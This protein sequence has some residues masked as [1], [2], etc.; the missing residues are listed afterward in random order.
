L[1]TLRSTRHVEPRRRRLRA[2]LARCAYG[3]FR[4]DSTS[5]EPYAYFE[6]RRTLD[7]WLSETAS[8]RGSTVSKNSKILVGATASRAAGAPVGM[9]S[10]AIIRSLA[11]TVVATAFG[12][13]I[14]GAAAGVS[15]AIDLLTT[16]LGRKDREIYEKTIGRLEGD[17]DAFARSER[18]PRALIDQAL[19]AARALIAARG[20]TVSEM[21]D[22]NLDSE[23]VSD[24]VAARGRRELEPLDNDAVELC[25]QI[26]RSAYAALLSEGAAL[27]GLEVAFRRVVLTTLQELPRDVADAVRVALESFIADQHAPALNRASSPRRQLGHRPHAATASLDLVWDPS[28]GVDFPSGG[29]NEYRM[30]IALYASNERGDVMAEGVEV[31]LLRTYPLAMVRDESRHHDRPLLWLGAE[32]LLRT[33]LDMPAGT[34]RRFHL[35]TLVGPSATVLYDSPRAIRVV[36]GYME[37]ACEDAD[38]FGALLWDRPLIQYQ[39]ERLVGSICTR[40]VLELELTSRNHAARRYDVHVLHDGY[41]PLAPHTDRSEAN[42][43]SHIGVEIR[44]GPPP[45]QRSLEG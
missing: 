42:F 45:I 5:Q 3:A 34:K 10:P 43:R 24:A 33:A 18:V 2:R 22:L 32:P 25:L 20:A 37:P 27:P 29:E 35:L 14:S 11:K 31:R 16:R 21:V 19:E 30:S 44:P 13:P 4:F 15:E 1:S 9:A 39:F 38:L 8:R 26:V 41:W 36:H 28:R 12:G 7:C 17:L 23:R 40:H 6:S